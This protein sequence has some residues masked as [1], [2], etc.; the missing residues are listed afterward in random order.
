YETLQSETENRPASEQ[1]PSSPP[2]PTKHDHGITSVVEM[3]AAKAELAGRT[4]RTSARLRGLIDTKLKGGW[5]PE[6]LAYAAWP[7][8][9]EGIRSLAAVIAHRIEDL[10]DPPAST[11]PSC[12]DHGPDAGCRHSP[13]TGWLHAAEVLMALSSNTPIAQEVAA[14]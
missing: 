6:P 8:L 5:K 7:E 12:P 3:L 13:G 11:T 2:A 14:L 4:F 1:K 10:G 9:L